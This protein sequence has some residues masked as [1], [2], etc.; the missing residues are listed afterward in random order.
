MYGDLNGNGFIDE[1]DLIIFEDVFNNENNYDGTET[2]ILADID[3]SGGIGTGDIRV[4]RTMLKTNQYGGAG[5]D[6]TGNY[7]AN[8]N[9]TTETAQFYTDINL[10]SLKTSQDVM[11]AI[12]SPD[13]DASIFVKGE[14]ME[15]ILRIWVK[16]PP[17][18]D[19]ECL[20]TVINDGSGK[21]SI[22]GGDSSIY[23]D[24]AIAGL[25]SDSIIE[26]N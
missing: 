5:N 3:K 22:T 1:E 11:I 9:Y 8:P 13:V 12:T 17:I 16:R 6:Y 15:G 4:I 21:C 20:V 18:S 25:S 10:P 2:Y 19:I 7:I 26:Q 24:H 14:V 23:V